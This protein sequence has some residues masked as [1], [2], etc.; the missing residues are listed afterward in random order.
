[1]SYFTVRLF[2]GGRRLEGVHAGF[3]YL[4]SLKLTGLVNPCMFWL[5]LVRTG[6][7]ECLP[8]HTE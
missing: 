2:S 8:H 1:M 4:F 3:M 6:M 5:S 7:P